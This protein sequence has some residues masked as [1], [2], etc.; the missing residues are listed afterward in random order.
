M[1]MA[2]FISISKAASIANV[3]ASDIQKKIDTNLLTTTRG[4]IHIEDLISCYPQVQEE[5]ADMH[6]LVEKIKE[7]S[8]ESGAAKQHGEVSIASLKKE[9]QMLKINAK[10]YREQAEKY[11]ELVMTICENL[12][13]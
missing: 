8:F 12:N 11:E 13:G 6:S 10:Y 2:Q 5:Q 7:Q 3:H 4:K 1:W 9:Q